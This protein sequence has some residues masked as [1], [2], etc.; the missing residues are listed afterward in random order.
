MRHLA[1]L[2]DS[3]FDNARYVPEAAAV[4][5]HLSAMLPAG[6][7]STL[8]AHDGDVVANI[9]EQL[10]RLPNEITHIALSV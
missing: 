5:D 1:L 8:V 4:I 6:F 7:S 3:I 2:G 10:L 9:E